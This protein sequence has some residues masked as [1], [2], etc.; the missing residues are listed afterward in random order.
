M[1]AGSPSTYKYLAPSSLAV[2]NDRGTVA[3][4]HLWL[5]R[6]APHGERLSPKLGL[7]DRFTYIAHQLL[8]MASPKRSATVAH[9]YHAGIQL[10]ANAC[11]AIL[12][13]AVS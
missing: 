6:V 4:S 13:K 7:L 12:L 2:A 1:N 9:Q 11:V 5:A 3:L 10:P 8:R